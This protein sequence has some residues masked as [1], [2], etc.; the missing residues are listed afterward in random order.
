MRPLGQN[1][2]DPKMPLSHQAASKHASTIDYCTKT[3][4]KVADPHWNNALILII[5]TCDHLAADVTAPLYL[6]IA[7]LCPEGHTCFPKIR[8][9]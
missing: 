4:T 6:L 8:I 7:D 1:T 2:L 9:Q 5:G 3:T